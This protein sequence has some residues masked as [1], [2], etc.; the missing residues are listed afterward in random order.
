MRIKK[1]MGALLF[2]A[3]LTSCGGNAE[4]DPIEPNLS[5]DTSQVTEAERTETE[6]TEAEKTKAEEAGTEK[7]EA[8]KAETEKSEAEKE[9]PENSR[10]MFD[11]VMDKWKRGDT[12]ALYPY[13]FDEMLS[14][15]GR[16]TIVYIFESITGTFGEIVSNSEPEMIAF[17]GID[18]YSSAVHLENADVDISMSLKDAKIYGFS[19]DIRF[20]GE[21]DVTHGSI[22]EHYFLLNG[23]NAV[24]T[25]FESSESAP[26]V[27]LISGSGPCDYNEIVGLLSPMKDLAMG[28]AGHGISLLRLEKRTLRFSSDFSTTDGIEEEYFKDCRAALAYLKELDNTDGVYLLRSV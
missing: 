1:M 23:L 5:A 11:F 16:D 22:R 6:K 19:R 17:N 10:E 27:L 3:L 24:Y 13:L 14:L 26:A 25:C 9:E 2:L 7:A 12:E 8:E 4:K 28:L 20:T 15:C 18:V 21:F